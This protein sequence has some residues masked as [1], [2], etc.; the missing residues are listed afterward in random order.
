MKN[1]KGNF[2]DIK[3]ILYYTGYVILGTGSLMLIPIITSI[4]FREWATVIDFLISINITLSVGLVFLLLGYKNN[5]KFQWKHG[6]IISALSWIVLTFLCAIP[7]LL[8]GHINSLL[9][10]CFDVMSG[11]TTTGLILIQ[12]LEHISYGLNMWRHIIT[13]VGGQGMVVLAL[14][15][16]V[17]NTAGA[18]QMYVG[19][20]KDIELF[21]NVKNTA[22]IIWIISM[23][24]LLVGTVV[25]WINGITIGLKPVSALFH[26]MF[27]FM[28][29][30]S[31]GGF[32]PMSQNLLYYHSFSYEIWSIIFF[33]LG[34]FNFGLHFAIWKG[35]RKEIFKNIETRTFF[36]TGTLTSMLAILAL[37]K[38]SGYVGA[39]SLFRRG[40]YN[41]LSAHTTTGFA[42]VYS[43]QF[44]LQWGDFG[45]LVMVIAMLLG[46]CACSTAGGIKALRVGIIFKG[47]FS[48]IR[49]NLSSDRK[50]QVVKMHYIKEQVLQ[51]PIIKGAAMI[52]LCYIMLF[53]IGTG[54]GAY[55]GYPLTESAFECASVVG[56]VG[57]SIGVTSTTMPVVMK[58]Y[59]IVAMYLGRLEFISVFALLGFL[60]GGIRKVCLK[61]VKR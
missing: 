26:G 3:I 43:R 15:L 8:S 37:L 25:L 52:A 33:T 17:K 5:K 59:Y 55:Y 30:W 6:L 39:S 7:Y 11:F 1:S 19:E 50:V 61:Y 38:S 22:R 40:I 12:D 48:D 28:S 20:G 18:Y 46:G 21:P 47:I 9:D 58:I 41:L 35:N 45:V 10:A 53:T 24:Y 4:L 34:S 23:V 54:I 2:N 51:E 56:N 31:T 60:F 14:S 57:L 27:V 13:F 44:A 42:N 16:L 32:A 29:A 49:K 36:I